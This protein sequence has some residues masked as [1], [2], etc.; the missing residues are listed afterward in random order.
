MSAGSR[1]TNFEVSAM[2]MRWYDTSRA[3]REAAARE[4]DNELCGQGFQI[5]CVEN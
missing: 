5:P 1:R 4:F 3:M 2:M